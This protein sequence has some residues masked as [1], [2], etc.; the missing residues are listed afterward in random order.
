ME[1]FDLGFVDSGEL[2]PQEGEGSKAFRAFTDYCNLGA[3]RSLR[4]LAQAYRLQSEGEA[5]AVLP[6]TVRPATLEQWSSTFRWVERSKLYERLRAAAEREADMM[7]LKEMKGR[8]IDHAMYLL[9]LA[10]L[11]LQEMA[12]ESSSPLT[13]AEARQYIETA[14]RIE[15]EAR[16]AAAAELANSVAEANADT[17]GVGGRIRVIEVVKRYGSPGAAEDDDE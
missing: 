6:P 1:G 12:L 3:G 10:G 8:H 13:P 11:K 17:A 5:R 4:K 15:R 14:V 7:A 2:Q 16:G 9:K